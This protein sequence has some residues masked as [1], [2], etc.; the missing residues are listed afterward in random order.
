LSGR[1]ITKPAAVEI[2]IRVLVLAVGV[3]VLLLVWT[4]ER[5][6]IDTDITNALPIA[7]SVVNDAKQMLATLPNAGQ[8]VVDLEL[9]PPDR[10]TLL[11]FGERVVQRLHTSGLFEQVGLSAYRQLYPL[12]ID[13][14]IEQLPYLFSAHQL[15]ADIAPQLSEASIRDR[16]QGA[17]SNLQDLN[18]LG[19]AATLPR[20]PLGWHQ[21][22]LAR[23]QPLARAADVSV[24]DQFLV[25]KD[26][27]H[28]LVVATPRHSATD[29][30]HGRAIA[31]L[32][33]AVEIDLRKRAKAA[34]TSVEMNAMGAYRAALDNE[35]MARRD[36]RRA[37][38]F[39]TLGIAVL[40]LIS[41]KRPWLGFMALLPAVAGTIAALFTLSLF[42]PNLSLIAVGFGGA[43]IAITVDHAIAFLLFLDRT[44]QPLTGADAAR[45]VWAVGLI[46]TLTTVGAFISLTF[47]G[48]DLLAQVGQFAALGIGF[49][50][51]FVHTVFR[52]I[53]RRVQA[54]PKPREPFM[55][56]IAD[57]IALRAK[58]IKAIAAMLL[59][60]AML[61][62]VRPTFDIDL[63]AMNA[64]SPETRRA[65]ALIQETWGGMGDNIYIGLTA[66]DLPALREKTDRLAPLLAN[67]RQDNIL[68]Q[69]VSV[70]EV[71]P[72]LTLAKENLKA[73]RQF[74][75]EE[76]SRAFE[77]NLKT[78]AGQLGFAP[79]AFN[80]FLAQIKS[81][82]AYDDNL[83]PQ[84]FNL[85]QLRTPHGND[86]WA[87]MVTAA[88]G[89]RYDPAQFRDKVMATVD[90]RLY[91]PGYFAQHLGGLISQTFTRMAVIVAVAAFTL[92]L[93]F[94]RSP[95][96][97]LIA[98]SPLM[99]AL[100]CTLGTLGLLGRSLDI[101]AIML[102]IVVMGMGIDYSLYIVR[103]YQHFP[104]ERHPGRRIVR[105]TVV[106]AGCSTLM[107][108]GTL[109]VADHVVL[110]S[111]GLSTTIAIAYALLMTFALLPTLQTWYGRRLRRRADG[112]S[113]NPTPESR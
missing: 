105:L 57:T 50:F 4:L 32:M 74:W 107:G 41:F 34:G 14:I 60:M 54:S 109:G 5:I 92:L 106:L 95:L 93:I 25:T 44:D 89:P 18:G 104:H 13:R 12:L 30:R 80:A 31:D 63:Q 62:W 33:A 84:L 65:E 102:T 83:P 82:P 16:L 36:T 58:P 11:G 73:W 70:A 79:A 87:A 78:V 38:L 90:A 23:L 101:P 35:S 6:E 81:L 71:A 46:A 28:L 112:A 56:L 29:T 113:Q 20:D 94:F 51:L 75:H 19:L 21:Q 68:S 111:A 64:L 99:A 2:N 61:P 48:F 91:D 100:I 26:G 108:F 15:A 53:F 59:I 3:A 66:A 55:A 52:H 88:P 47:S 7:D 37:I 69:S 42:R 110:R 98:M 40:F 8:V 27:R 45:N 10:Q 43:V 17:L 72:G 24:V 22:V 85:L 1:N 76:R 103:A 97:A 67:L 39:A 9:Q 96:Q 49:A 86:P 77:A